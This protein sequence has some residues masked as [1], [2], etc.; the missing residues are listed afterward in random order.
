MAAVRLGL[1][2]GTTSIKTA[3]YDPAGRLL[4]LVEK[5]APQVTGRDGK[6]EQDMN[7]VW[8]VVL[9]ALSDMTGKLRGLQPES[10]GVSAQGDGFWA[11]DHDGNAVSPAML[12]N[13]TRAASRLHWLDANG[14]SGKVGRA[15]NTALW[16][17]TSGMLWV[18]LKQNEPELAERVA[19]LFT[20]GDWIGWKLTGNV[21]TDF[22]NASIPFLDLNTRAYD[23][24][25]LEALDCA[26]L[27]SKLA[28]P[29][30]AVSLLGRL[31][32]EIAKATRLP[33]GL[34]VS[35]PTLD[36]AAMIVGMG[37]DQPGQTM[38][39]MGT[40][41]V[42]NILTDSVETSEQPVGATA[43]HA[44]SDVI[45]RILAPTTGAAAFNWFTELHPLSLG[46]ETPSEIAA[47][48]NE[49]VTTIP[50]GAN[51]VTFLP[52][53]NGERAPFVEPSIT[54]SFHGLT[55]RS[56]KAD[57]G[58]AVLEGGAMSLRHCFE[59]EG[60][61]PTQPVLLTGGGSKNSLWCQ[62]IADVIGAPTLVSEGSDQ[63][64]W[65]AASIG[66]AAAG[67]GDVMSLVKREER[68]ICY[69]P[70]NENHE[71]YNKIF[72]RYRLLSDNARKLVNQLQEL[73]EP[74]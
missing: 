24:D 22:S 66:A 37:M 16:P 56:T 70:N 18:W 55:A 12:W 23:D 40:T 14:A 58:R 35:T 57:M 31:T 67:L 44:T 30:S 7:A 72:P 27:K 54:A 51:G 45:I 13:D 49:M 61:N 1:D 65:G 34:P 68:T 50:P 15:C 6:S 36:L 28:T 32:P 17:G 9:D 29:Q 60:V 20:C 52:Y 25:A 69:T 48:L 26:D 47:K 42:V 41:A 59:M 73:E 46:G 8:T 10:L 64:L 38:M 53:L 63:G 3:A 5:P 39:I 21:A 74:K 11:I 4:A 71:I 19:H 2:V 33:E 62:I 43:F